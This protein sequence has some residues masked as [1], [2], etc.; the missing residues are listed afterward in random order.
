MSEYFEKK[1]L[2]LFRDEESCRERE[3]DFY[4][5]LDLQT[6]RDSYPGSLRQHRKAAKQFKAAANKTNARLK[7]K[8]TKLNVI[9]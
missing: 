8:R 4:D 9:E 5:S 3:K 2:K 7:L 6:P 1:F